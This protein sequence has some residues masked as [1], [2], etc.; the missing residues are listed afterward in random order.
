M[1]AGQTQLASFAELNEAVRRG[2][3]QRYIAVPIA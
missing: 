2:D 1:Q 3:S